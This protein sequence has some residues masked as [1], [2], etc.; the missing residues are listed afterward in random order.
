MRLPNENWHLPSAFTRIKSLAS[1]VAK[2]QHTLKGVQG[3]DQ[4]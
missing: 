4:E 3:T 1:A 2:L